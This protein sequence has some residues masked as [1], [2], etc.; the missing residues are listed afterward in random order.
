[1]SKFNGILDMVK[2]SYVNVVFV[3]VLGYYYWCFEFVD[4][5]MSEDWIM[6]VVE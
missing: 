4:V 3:I 2:F 5:I 6:V 1:M